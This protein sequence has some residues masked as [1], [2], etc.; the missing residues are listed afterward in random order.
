MVRVGGNP[1]LGEYRF[2]RPEGRESNNKH[3][4]LMVSESMLAKIKTIA[5]WQDFVREAI[6]RALES[7]E[8]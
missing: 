2:K 1:G 6:S 4:Q 3:L 7:L 8:E 5:N